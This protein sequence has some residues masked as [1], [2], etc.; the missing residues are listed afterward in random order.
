MVS[1]V[2]VSGGC[3]EAFLGTGTPEVQ[4]MD[5]RGGGGVQCGHALRPWMVCIGA[6]SSGQSGCRHCAWVLAAAV[7]KEGQLLLRPTDDANRCQQQ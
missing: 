2:V 3:D 6:G 1:V 7:V 5:P 4:P